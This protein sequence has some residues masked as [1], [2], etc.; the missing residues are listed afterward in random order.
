M[1]A[2]DGRKVIC[3]VG[4]GGV[5]KTTTAAALALQAAMEGKRALVLTIDP[6]RRLANSLGLREMGNEETRIEPAHFAAAKLAPRGEMWAMMLDLKHTWDELVKRQARSPQQ[7]QAILGNQLYQ[8]L[9]TAMAG[10]LEYMAMEKV[11]EVYTSGRFN[12][13]V[14]DTPPTSNALD[15]LHAADRILDVLDNN[16]MRLLLGPMLKAGRF[17]FRLLAAPSSLVLRTLARF[18]GSD[19][20]GDLAAFM[21]AFEGMYEGFKDRAARVKALL[22]SRD[23]AFVLV[24]SANPLTTREALFFHRALEQDGIRTAA[25]VVNRVQRDP[26]RHGGP[27]NVAAL[28]EALQLAQI[29]DQDQ[30]AERLCQT[31]TEQA[32]LADLDRREVE[33]LRETLRGVPLFTVPR[34]RRDV[35]D[36][37]GLWQIDGY[38]ADGYRGGD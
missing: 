38:L 17:G 33:H 28:K 22:A 8:T 4:S 2:L 34:L 11:Y 18:T 26:R 25:V 14:L 6:A 21:M 10:S 37:A 24:T 32:I 5:G 1:K 15:F 3:C 29:K 16:A 13:I 30:L 20:L 19:F 27:D 36:L 9:S 7:A 23:A 35:H 12:L 31:M